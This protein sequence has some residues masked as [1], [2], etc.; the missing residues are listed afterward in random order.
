MSDRDNSGLYRCRIRQVPLYLQ[1]FGGFA[2][3]VSGA[4]KGVLNVDTRY[5]EGTAGVR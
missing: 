5:P 1:K 4:N 2:L 3:S